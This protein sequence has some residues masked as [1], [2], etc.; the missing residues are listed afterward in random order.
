M[1]KNLKNISKQRNI[2]IDCLKAIAAF[3]VVAIHFG[4]S[5]N[6]CKGLQAI[7]RF[8]VPAFL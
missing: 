4:F 5:G 7:F 8:G 2:G 6:I 1:D 3:G